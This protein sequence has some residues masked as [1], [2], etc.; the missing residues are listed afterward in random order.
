MPRSRFAQLCLVRETAPRETATRR[1]SRAVRTTNSDVDYRTCFWRDAG[2]RSCVRGDELRFKLANDARQHRAHSVGRRLPKVEGDD[3]L[4]GFVVAS[5]GASSTGASA[6][7]RHIQSRAW[8]R[9]ELLYFLLLL[10]SSSSLSFRIRDA[11]HSRR[12]RRCRPRRTSHRPRRPSTHGPRARAPS[13]PPPQRAWH[14]PNESRRR[15]SPAGP[16]AHSA[17]VLATRCRTGIC[18]RWGLHRPSSLFPR[19]SKDVSGAYGPSCD[20]HESR[21][22]RCA[23]CWY[24]ASILSDELS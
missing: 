11:G 6:F 20:M 5:E 13:V 7:S 21:I 15:P 22:L 10:L 23:S 2:V 12:R 16:R 24:V 14:G 18:R 19:G 1:E 17:L 4:E 8:R 3:V 9:A